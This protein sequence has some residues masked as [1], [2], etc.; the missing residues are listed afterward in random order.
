MAIQ[1]QAFAVAAPGLA[2]L[3][4]Q[5][6]T[7]LGVS[8]GS[9]TAA[10]V[11][12]DATA[13]A[14]FRVN[15][16]SRLATRVL[17]RLHQFTARDFATLEKRAKL[18]PWSQVIAPGSTVAL[19]VTCRKSRLYHSD[20]VA[21]R[22]G[23]AIV[24]GVPGIRIEVGVPD[25]APVDEGADQEG[26]GHEGTGHDRAGHEGD[27]HEGG[28]APSAPH[29][30][31]SPAPNAARVQRLLI[32]FDRDVCTISA[33][34]SG[35]RLDRRGWRLDSAKAPLRETLAAALLVAAKWPATAPLVDPFCG[36]GTI[37]IEAALMARRIAP[38]L[39]REF[40][41]EFWPG[42]N[43]EIARTIREVA[44]ADVRASLPIAIVAGDRDAGAVEATRANAARAGVLDDL[45][46]V[47]QPLSAL[48]LSELGPNGWL[49]TNPPYG[50]RTGTPDTLRALW[51]QLGA[52]VRAGG[53]GWQLGVVVPDP[54]V[55][56]EL[57]LSLSRSVT[58]A[59]GG[60]PIAFHHSALP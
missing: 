43:P 17:I 51:G 55:L 58:T 41:C 49:V 39:S 47:H 54:N 8:I 33:D 13:D 1:Y 57:R 32:R 35:D 19:S 40:A 11:A 12:F 29:A 5:E 2:P 20:A 52:T 21:E 44:R 50:L 56:R 37:A 45:T 34:S 27:G 15:C 38:G 7:T 60:R 6:L 10:G 46:V 4:A 18:V 9:V 31:L 36:A 26:T 16:W 48:R 59:T 42:A 24:Q 30:T 3:V 28:N 23:R 25:D 22:V 53:R 14:L